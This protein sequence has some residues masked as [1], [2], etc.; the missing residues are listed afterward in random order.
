VWLW[1]AWANGRGYHWARTAFVTFF[2]LLT[3]VPL[4]GLGGDRLPYTWRDVIATTVLWLVGLAA[5]GLIFSQTASLYYQ[6]R[7]APR[8]ATPANG[9]GR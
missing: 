1:L 7:A 3:I 5:M 9:T 8:A 2:G 4:F 6:R